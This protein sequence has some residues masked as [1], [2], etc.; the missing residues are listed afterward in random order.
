MFFRRIF[1]FIYKLAIFG[2]LIELSSGLYRWKKNLHEKFAVMRCKMTVPAGKH[3]ITLLRNFRQ[4]LFKT[5]NMFGL[6][7]TMLITTTRGEL[8]Y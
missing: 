2:I 3:Q 8:K 4:I 1:I 6:H 7:K 5:S